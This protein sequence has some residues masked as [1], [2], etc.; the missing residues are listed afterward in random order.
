MSC[1]GGR[2]SQDLY[3]NCCNS[4]T[5]CEFNGDLSSVNSEPIYV[6]KVYDAVLFNL[7]GMKTVQNTSFTPALPHGHRVKRVVDIRVKKYFNPCNV[8]D[9]IN[10]KLDVNTS[11]SGAT[12]LQN[13]NGDY[14]QTIGADGTFSEKILYAETSECDDQCKGTPIF[15][16][17][18]I[19]I[20]GNVIIELDLLLCDA[21]NIDSIFTVCANVNIAEANNPLVLTNFFEICMPSAIDTAFLPRFT[22]VTNSA[23]EA[24]L[25]TNNCGRDLA[26]DSNGCIRGNLI[27]AIC[28]TCEKKIL[29]PVQLCVLSTGYAKA[30]LQQ[31]TICGAFPTLFPN[32]M[33]VE[34]TAAGCCD[35]YGHSNH[36][37]HSHT[38]HGGYDAYCGTA[39]SGH[40]GHHHN[41]SRCD[42]DDCDAGDGCARSVGQNSCGCDDDCC[43]APAPCKPHRPQPRR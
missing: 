40:G 1:F 15:G 22:E 19:A 14:L 27:I 20:T 18:N 12:F 32:Q 34:D 30:P 16:T 3:Q 37:G 29:V 4:N 5:L 35:H 17:Q 41:D 7:Q 28:V 23:C 43:D 9:P 11:I 25:A 8:D 21:C 24:R 42:L 2:I 36:G 26:V 13:C 6:Q 38:G 39:A 31:N 33:R 10:L